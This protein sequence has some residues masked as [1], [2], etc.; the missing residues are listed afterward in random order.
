MQ[1]NLEVMIWIIHHDGDDYILDDASSV[2]VPCHSV[3]DILQTQFRRHQVTKDNG[4]GNYRHLTDSVRRRRSVDTNLFHTCFM[5][6]WED[7]NKV[8]SMKRKAKGLPV[9]TIPLVLFVDDTS[10]NKSK[11]WNKFIEWHLTIAGMCTS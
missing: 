10:G 7:L 3:G 5:Q 1:G 11:K 9:V 4:D 6:E 2:Y 8:H